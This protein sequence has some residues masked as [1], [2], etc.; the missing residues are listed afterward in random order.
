MYGEITRYC[1][2]I[3]AHAA[4]ISDEP[5]LSA[6]TKARLTSAIHSAITEL[7][8]AGVQYRF[9]NIQAAQ[10]TVIFVSSVLDFC[11]SPN[12][13]LGPAAH[14]LNSLI[15]GSLIFKFHRYRNFHVP[16]AVKGSLQS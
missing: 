14:K 8:F 13:D 12:S 2:N 1:S 15:F 10:S 9:L 16:P 6:N 11:L 3:T 5:C 4:E 7:R